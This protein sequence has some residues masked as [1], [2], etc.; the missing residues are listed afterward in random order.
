MPGFRAA[1]PK[2]CLRGPEESLLAI[3]MNRFVVSPR[4]CRQLI[5]LPALRPLEWPQRRGYMR[6]RVHCF[7]MA[8]F[9][10]GAWPF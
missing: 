7:M 5:S 10:E 1:A 3:E 9:L 4:S 2:P 8:V 6:S